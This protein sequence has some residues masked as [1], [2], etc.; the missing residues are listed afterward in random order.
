MRAAVRGAIVKTNIALLTQL[1]TMPFFGTRVGLKN[2]MLAD[3]LY[4]GETKE[5][6]RYCESQGVVPTAAW[7]RNALVY[8]RYEYARWIA[9]TYCHGVLDWAGV[10]KYAASNGHLQLLQE[11]CE[12]VI[13]GTFSPDIVSQAAAAAG[14][15]DLLKWLAIRYPR[16][17]GS[18]ALQASAAAGGGH[19]H[20][21]RWYIEENGLSLAGDVLILLSAIRAPNALEIAEYLYTKGCSLGAT[22][23]ESAV[24]Q[25]SLPIVKWLHERQC[26][27]SPK[28]FDAAV[29]VMRSSSFVFLCVASSLE[30]GR[31]SFD[32][33]VADEKYRLL[34]QRKN[35][36]PCLW[37]S[38]TF[39]RQDGTSCRT[40]SEEPKEEQEQEK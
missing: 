4:Y 28:I 36:G 35:V 24:T 13:S 29:A 25:R 37:S 34:V 22:A 3:A 16:K 14:H 15:L 27:I 9:E 11:A 30:V 38:S 6:A 17:P 7:A 33:S 19:L 31:R 26:P 21:L 39:H 1:F 5:I 32:S 23:M 40:V 12:K 10:A 8:G 20:I 18:L 2:V